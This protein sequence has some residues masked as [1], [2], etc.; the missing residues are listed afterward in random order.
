MTPI[1]RYFV[2]KS[3]SAGARTYD[4]YAGL[5]HE[6]NVRLIERFCPDTV[7]PSR[8][9]DIGIGTGSLA[10][11]LLQRFPRAALYGCDLAYAM[12]QQARA[13]LQQIHAEHTTIAADAEQLPF[14]SCSFELAA[15]A[16]TFQWLD[17]WSLAVQ[18][19][20]RVLTPGGVFLFSAF[21]AQTFHELRASYG[22]AC[23]ET[24]YDRGEALKLSTTAESV[25]ASLAGGR[26]SDVHVE[27]LEQ[28]S[29]Y[30][31]VNE[32]VRAIKGMGARNASARRNKTAGVRTVWNRMTLHYEKTFGSPSGIPATFEIIMG[33]AR[34][35]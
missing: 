30:S 15:T 27:T 33:S 4:Q 25:K 31:S 6:M 24:G 11:K 2:K 21:G 16:F 23:A 1:D 5:Q 7:Q 34:R 35:I 9:L 13:R 10:I 18:E 28:V 17:D 12:L 19:V 29:F 26:F 22:A 3:F 14:T 20:H 8:I 32:L